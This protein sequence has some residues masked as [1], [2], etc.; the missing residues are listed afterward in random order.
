[1]VVSLKDLKVIT[2]TNV[3]Q[4]VLNESNRKPSKIWVDK[5]SKLGNRS[6]KPNHH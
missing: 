5:E 2:I 4:K 3:F 1:M 6:M